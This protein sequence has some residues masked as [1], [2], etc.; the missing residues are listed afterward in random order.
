MQLIDTH[1]HLDEQAFEQDLEEVL[2]RAAEAGVTRILSIGITEETSRNAVALAEKYPQISA[3]V[4]I[5]PNYVSQMKHGDWESIVELSSHSQVVAIGETGLDR[6]W[7]YAPIDQQVEWFDRHIE[8]SR[9]IGKPFV[10]HCR[11]AE[12]DVV[13]QLQRAAQNGPLSGV[14]HSFCGD[15]ATA[16]ACLELGMHISFAGMLTY[17]RNEELRATAATIPDDRL[18]V[19]TDS[20]YLAP[21]PMR[22]K[23]NEPAHVAHTAK[24]LA[25]VRGI[26]PG[27]LSGITTSNAT[28]LFQLGDQ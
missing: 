11:E 22:G 2:S 20:P 28:R 17:K 16:Q 8:L 14:M 21:V 6:Y 12:A 18:L 7:D 27:E 26:S 9:E 1:A 5:Q 19:E 10:V 3:V 13:A 15:Q 25:E 24:C 4:G 23:R